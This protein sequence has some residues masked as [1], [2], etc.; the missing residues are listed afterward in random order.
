MILLEQR[1]LDIA[2]FDLFEIVDALNYM[3]EQVNNRNLVLGVFSGPSALR[4]ILLSTEPLK[5]PIF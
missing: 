5:R 3:S 2:I 4:V 1:S